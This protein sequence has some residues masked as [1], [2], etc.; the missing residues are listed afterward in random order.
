LRETN[1]RVVVVVEEEDAKALVTRVA[2]ETNLDK[3]CTLIVI[4]S[5]REEEDMPP[6]TR[7]RKVG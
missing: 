3:G 5:F 2:H 6:E 4:F 7:I 1:A